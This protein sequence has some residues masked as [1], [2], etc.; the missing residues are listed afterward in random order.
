MLTRRPWADVPRER[1]AHVITHGGYHRGEVGSHHS[2]P[3]DRTIT[4]PRDT[5]TG[6]LD[7]AERA[8]RDPRESG[9]PVR[10]YSPHS[11][12]IVGGP[13]PFPVAGRSNTSQILV[14][15]NEPV[16]SDPKYAFL[17][18]IEKNHGRQLRRYLGARMR[19]AATDVPDLV[20]E[21]FLRL[22]RIKDHDTIRNPRA[23]LYTVASH[24]L[25]QHALRQTATPEFIQIADVVS[26]LQSVPDTDPALQADLDQSFEQ[27]GRGLR[28]V[29]PGAY[30]TLMLH[31]YHGLP[32]K[33]ISRRLNVSHVTTKRYLAKA[34][35]YIEKQLEKGRELP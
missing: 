7:K 15:H 11:L 24:V 21:I 22:L 9:T 1:L 16:T 14:S 32:L 31:R 29:S 23:Y 3:I 34:L 5:F 19:N 18:A 28:A 33:E 20:Q 30:A 17:T 4:R 35:E 25:H 10:P 8:H 27:I 6:Y 12:Y 13:D 26:E 2:Q